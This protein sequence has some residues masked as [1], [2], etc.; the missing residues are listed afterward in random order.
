[1]KRGNVDGALDSLGR[2]KELHFYDLAKVYSDKDFASAVGRSAPGQNRQ[3]LIV[4]LI[5]GAPPS[6]RICFC[7]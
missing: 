2:A 5:L 4:E 3:A 7:G 6:P 1:M